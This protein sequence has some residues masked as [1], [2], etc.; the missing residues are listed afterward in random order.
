MDEFQIEARKIMACAIKDMARMC[1]HFA[2]RRA[3]ARLREV[4]A[5]AMREAN[6]IYHTHGV[7]HAHPGSVEVTG[8]A[9]ELVAQ[10]AR[11]A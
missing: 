3:T 2:C 11:G 1:N 4:A 5:M 8:R 9:N 6:I 7:P 10:A